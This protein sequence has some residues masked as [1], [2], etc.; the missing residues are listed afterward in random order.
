MEKSSFEYTW[1]MP[2][3]IVSE[4]DCVK[5]NA[6]LLSPLGKRALIV[7]GKSSATNGSLA[8]R[9]AALRENGQEFEVFDEVTPNPVVSCIQKGA[10]K[11]REMYADFIVGIGGGSPMDAAKAIAALARQPR[12][13]EEIFS[14]G[15]SEDILPV[16]AVPTTAGTGSEV[17][18][19]AIVTNDFK[20]TKT[21]L[22]APEMFPKLAFLDGKYMLSLPRNTTIHTAI[23]AL[24]HAVEGMF[25]TKSTPQGDLVALESI[26]LL[27]GIFPKL[28][29]S[30]A[31]SL[32][33]R[34]TLLYASM[35]AG[36]VIAQAG[37]TAVHTLGYALTYHYGTDHGEAN[38]V[39]L[40]EML[41]LAEER[42]PER[43]EK[44]LRAAGTKDAEE[45]RR[46]LKLLLKG[47]IRYPREAL[48]RYAEEA[49]DSPKLKGTTYFRD[50]E[51]LLRIYLK[52]DIVKEA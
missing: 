48:I 35:L 44:I 34:D 47:H 46:V 6:L 29:A 41:A 45:F 19:Y 23:D 13:D 10:A 49:A 14:G 18:P 40:G 8:D 15:W 16:V 22:S 4:R 11:A 50:K 17:T 31:L 36:T 37:T 51:D 21:S 28:Q 25:T 5:N 30:S 2:T 24:S 52:S 12:T 1:Y 32:S 9:C 39:L 20:R 42:I 38:G 33:E 27:F 7:T 3:K 43:T 26:R